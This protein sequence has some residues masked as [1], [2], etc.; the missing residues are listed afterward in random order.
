M[1]TMIFFFIFSAILILIPPI[2]NILHCRTFRISWTRDVK[3]GGGEEVENDKIEGKFVTW[4][5]TI[6]KFVVY[7]L[8]VQHFN[9]SPKIPRIVAIKRTQFC[10]LVDGLK[11]WNLNCFLSERL[12]ARNIVVGNEES[13]KAYWNCQFVHRQ[14]RCCDRI[15]IDNL[16]RKV[17]AFSNKLL[18]TANGVIN[19][20]TDNQ[21]I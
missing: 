5:T 1:K 18:S 2:G 7:L 10:F 6:V 15:Q 8:Y 20:W 9:S 14:L 16:F 3:G 19:T 11:R 13:H 21:I 12:N 17:L 4:L